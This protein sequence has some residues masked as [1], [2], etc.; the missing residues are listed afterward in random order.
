MVKIQIVNKGLNVLTKM[1][2]MHTVQISPAEMNDLWSLFV[3]G[4]KWSAES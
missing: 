1:L 2:H 4:S 3:G